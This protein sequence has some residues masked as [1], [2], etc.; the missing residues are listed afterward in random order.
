MN[1]KVSILVPVYGVEQFIERCA[2]SLF[3]QTFDDIEYVFVNDCTP[4]NSISILERIIRK[5]PH[6]KNR[7]RIISHE[8]NKGL[9][10]ARNTGVENATGDYILHVDSDDYIEK[11]MIELLVNKA[12]AE[13]VDIV[14]CNSFLEWSNRKI[15]FNQ[16]FSENKDTMIKQ[17]LRIEATPSIWNK[18]IKRSLYIVNNI[19]TVEGVNYGEDLLVMPQLLY[20]TKKIAKI[21]KALYHYIQSNPNSYTQFFSEKNILDLKVVFTELESF[22]IKNKIEGIQQDIK[23]GKAKKKIEIVSFAQLENLKKIDISF[24]KTNVEKTISLNLYQKCL[25]YCYNSN[26]YLL[27]KLFRVLFNNIRKMKMLLR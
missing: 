10:G 26:N 16:T 27:L 22:F 3:E 20:Y 23:I 12:I 6:R 1:P 9:A 14:M 4:D 5:Y 21:D 2:I 15:I 11:D 7:I 24:F 25:L 8:A 17:I 19:K 13:D 18:L